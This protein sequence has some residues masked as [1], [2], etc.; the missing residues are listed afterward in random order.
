MKD[1]TSNWTCLTLS[2][3]EGLGNDMDEECEVQEFIIAAKFLTKHI[4]NID[5]IA[6]TFSPLW[7]SHK[8]FK[9][10]NMDNHTMLFLF[11]NKAN[12]D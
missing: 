3:R 7:W 4:L 5:A 2:D 8:G 6:K 11:N 12:A 9:I 1:L 10:R